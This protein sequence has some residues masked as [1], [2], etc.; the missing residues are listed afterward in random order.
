M[1]DPYPESLSRPELAARQLDRLQ[2]LLSEVEEKNPFWK[3]KFNSAGINRQDIQSLEDFRQ[4]PLLTKQELVDDQNA[5]PPFGTNLTYPLSGY[6]RLH[7][8]SGTTGKPMRWLDTPESWDWFME[9]WAQ[10]YRISGIT[11]DDIFA[12]PFSFGPFIGFWAA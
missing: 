11:S 1:S 8:T 2:A 12:F 6:S 9:C 10:I 3:S 4:F 7:Q 5:N